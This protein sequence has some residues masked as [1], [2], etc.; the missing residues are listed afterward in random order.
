MCPDREIVSVYADEELPSP[1]KEKLE[2][3]LSHCEACRKRLAAYR[4]LSG[5]I[6]D[7][8]DPAMTEEAVGAA[9]KRVM[10][11][12]SRLTRP[13]N[14]RP[15]R[16]PV[17][18]R[19]I[20]IPLPA[21][22]AAAV[23]FAVLALVWRRPAVNPETVAAGADLDIRNTVPV[24]DMEGALQYLSARDD[25]DYVILRLPERNFMNAGEPVIIKA[26]DYSGRNG[27]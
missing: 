1:W 11:R 27:R 23:L 22:A 13:E 15:Y 20:T 24:S 14:G 26:A 10:E 18:R 6:A 21:A 5:V 8:T 3:H 17:W 2:D 12:L 4:R 16:L 25:S 9:G 7:K 19:T